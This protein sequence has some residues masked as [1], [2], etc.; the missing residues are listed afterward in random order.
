MST[1]DVKRV[2]ANLRD[3][4]WRHGS[5]ASQARHAAVTLANRRERRIGRANVRSSEF[6][7][8]ATLAPM[9]PRMGNRERC[10]FCG[11]PFW[12]CPC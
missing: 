11:T 9:R 7:T 8:L 1:L 3:G 4:K 2:N 5:R 12:L 10:L 6:D